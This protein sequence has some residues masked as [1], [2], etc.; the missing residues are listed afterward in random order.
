MR[1]V[2]ILLIIFVQLLLG[3]CSTQPT[4]VGTGPQAMAEG[5]ADA[6]IQQLP[7]N[8]Y[9][10][11]RASVSADAQ[12]QF[13]QAR[14]LVEQEDWQGALLKLQALSQANPRLSGPSLNLALV[15][16]QLGDAEQAQRCF[17]QSINNNPRNIAA[18]NEY[19]IF[20]RKQGR[21]KEAE[22]IYLKALEEWEASAETHLDIGI[23]YD[24]YLGE[25]GKALQHYHRYQSLTGKQD[26][27][28]AGWITDLEHQN[29]PM[30]KGDQQ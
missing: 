28:V 9:L 11:G 27:I 17:Q 18:Y 3:G 22:T 13:E 29:V 30:A 5:V 12:R 23:L 2:T 6:P 16:Q 25:S 19:G 4:A 7:D 8:P 1:Y 14:V 21:F 10:K 15:Y 26:Q 20:L 24:L